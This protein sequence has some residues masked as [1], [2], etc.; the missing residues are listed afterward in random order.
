M[1]QQYRTVCY[2]RTELIGRK[3]SV[4]KSNTAANSTTVTKPAQSPA[5]VNNKPAQFPAPVNNKAA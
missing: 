2:R 4:I 1:K 5:P 3:Q